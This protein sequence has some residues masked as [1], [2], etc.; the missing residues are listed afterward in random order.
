[1]LFLGVEK[2]NNYK[3]LKLL[4]EFKKKHFGSKKYKTTMQFTKKKR[5]KF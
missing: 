4:F 2:K 5:T 1:M 3:K